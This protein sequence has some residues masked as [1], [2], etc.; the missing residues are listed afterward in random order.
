M[1]ALSVHEGGGDRK[2]NAAYLVGRRFE[3]RP[4]STSVNGQS[5][6]LPDVTFVSAD[7]QKNT[8]TAHLYGGGT[9]KLE[10]A[11]VVDAVYAGTLVESELGVAFVNEV[12]R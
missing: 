7:P 12:T 1:K 10:L 6:R 4:V 3:W 9:Q 8:I 2:I 11:A 5:R